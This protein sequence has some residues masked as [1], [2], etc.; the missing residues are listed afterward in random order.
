MLFTIFDNI[1]PC[2]GFI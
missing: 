1:M 2:I